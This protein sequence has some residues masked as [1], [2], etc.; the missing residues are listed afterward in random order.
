MTCIPIASD[1]VWF[2]IYLAASLAWLILPPVYSFAQC[3]SFK[4][5]IYPDLM[6]PGQAAHSIQ[7]DLTVSPHLFHFSPGRRRSSLFTPAHE[8]VISSH[9]GQY[10]LSAAHHIPNACCL[11]FLPSPSTSHLSSL[12]KRTHMLSS[13]LRSPWP[14]PIQPVMSSGQHSPGLEG[15][16]QVG[17]S[18]LLCFYGVKFMPSADPVCRQ[19]LCQLCIISRKVG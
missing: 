19:G 18:H 11:H 3:I 12:E 17:C 8:M 15:C 2:L 9:V 14:L 4:S 16:Q 1:I 6:M 7:C 13:A 5:C 10:N